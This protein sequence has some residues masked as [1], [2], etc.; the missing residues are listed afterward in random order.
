RPFRRRSKCGCRCRSGSI[1]RRSFAAYRPGHRACGPGIGPRTCFRWSRRRLLGYF[2]LGDDLTLAVRLKVFRFAGRAKDRIAFHE[3][4]APAVACHMVERR[5]EKDAYYLAGF[6]V[7][8]SS[9]VLTPKWE[10][11]ARRG[12][13]KPRRAGTDQKA[14][15]RLRGM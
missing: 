13:Q 2:G 1:V 5:A 6:C 11:S 15:I 7:S 12:R 9:H 10:K 8:K 4:G 3:P 14:E